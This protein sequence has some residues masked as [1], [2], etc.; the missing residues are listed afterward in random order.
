M[1]HTIFKKEGIGHH[2]SAPL[3][4]ER[5]QFL[6][7]L[8][9]RGTGR[10]CLR[11]YASR[12]NQI[13]RFLGLT[14][15]RDVTLNEIQLAARRWGRYCGPHRHLQP[16]PWSE[17][18]FT[19]LA[20]RWLRF[21]GKLILPHRRVH[22]ER[23]LNDYRECM[24]S[25]LRLAPVSIQGRLLD[26]RRFLEWAWKSRRRRNLATLSLEDVDKYIAMR[27]KR[28]GTVSIASGAG[29]LRAF[30]RFAERNNL[31]APGIAVGIKLPRIRQ[32]SS[33][34][35][36]PEWSDVERLLREAQ[37]R[38]PV[39]LRARAIL[40]LVSVYGLRRGEIVR[41]RL[42]DFDWRNRIFTVRRSKGGGYQQ[43]PICPTL[44]TAL[45]K[46]IERGRPKSSCLHLFISF[47]PPFGP[48]NPSSVYEVVSF[49]LNGSRI[50]ASRRGPHALRHAC[51]T[52]LLRRGATLRDIADFLGH[53][54]CQTV[55]F[56]A[57]VDQQL[58]RDVSALDLP[59]AL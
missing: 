39:D 6:L 25:E 13:V 30:F 45:R 50:R 29:A 18:S 49:R 20:K 56:Y 21:H 44:G 32:K 8:Q 3:V 31:C 11:I 40:L 53:R 26:T 17:P 4:L 41:L 7:Y 58:L 33:F 34:P 35:V 36:G 16:G 27:S 52:E 59:G 9:R 19:W 2:L 38:K 47:H 5:E 48:M 28:W 15:L 37:G 57:K 54:N 42:T 14:K 23:E 46:Y 10:V 22:F 12:L 24:T 51:A 1:F 43:F 55:S